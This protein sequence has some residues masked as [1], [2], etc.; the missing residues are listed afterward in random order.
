MIP[1]ANKSTLNYSGNKRFT[2]E[3]KKSKTMMKVQGNGG[4]LLV[5]HM[6]IQS[7]QSNPV[8]QQKNN[9]EHSV[10]EEHDQTV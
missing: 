10:H 7:K 1:L 6:S 2:I 4:T 3:V 9:N 5:N 8:V